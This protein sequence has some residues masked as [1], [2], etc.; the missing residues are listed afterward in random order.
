MNSLTHR[1]GF[2]LVKIRE[3][4]K[5]GLTV[6]LVSFPLS[7]SL[8]IASGATPVMG[9]ITAV[10][11]GLVAALLGGSHFNVVGPTGALS[12]LLL[13][14]ATTYGVMLMPFFT[15]IVGLFILAI[16]VLHLDKYIVFIP[17]SVLHG[18]TLGVAFIIGLNQLNFAFGLSG[19]PHHE[20]FL[21]NVWESIRH[22]G[23]IDPMTFAL[24]SSG[25]IL[26]LV[27][28]KRVPKIP[29]AIVLATGGI[30]LGYLSSRGI[31]GAELDTLA[32]RYDS[33]SGSLITLPTFSFSLL[34]SPA[35]LSAAAVA[36]VAVLET[37]ISAKIAD[38]ST[39]TNSDQR[40]EIFGLGAANIT[41]GLF[42]GIP[43]TAALARTSLNIKTGATH[44]TAAALN[45]VT[46]AVIALVFLSFFEY[47]PLAVVASILIYTAIRMIG[48][49][50]FEHLY[51]H[52]RA[53]FWTSLFVAVV[54][55]VEDPMMGIL[56]GA[57][58]ALLVSVKKISESQA[59][60]TVMRRDDVDS[61]HRTPNITEVD[62]HGDVLVYRIAGQLIY[63]NSQSHQKNIPLIGDSIHT[64]VFGLRNMF[65]IDVDGI[66]ALGAMID[67]VRKK[68]KHAVISGVSS[69]VEPML[70]Q[71]PW[72]KKL[73]KEGLVYSSTHDALAAIRTPE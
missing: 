29:W 41:S 35:L 70:M 11:A 24:A 26:L 2:V 5:A 42:G 34:H 50:H 38:A 19:L 33:L 37:L 72:F 56:V 9:I 25:L 22:V 10:W 23:Q 52:D 65:Y 62:Q 73:K 4:W 57:L 12:G 63:M 43:A 68:N 28:A 60:F 54:T 32:T 39:K 21:I 17:A 6:S 14:V 30:V 45:S 7:I 64:V 18:F 47:L 40:R 69:V 51:K 58:V 31:L 67:M 61:K 71:S 53:A 48:H 55:V 16:W 49:E 15:I 59:E 46:L 66:D 3:N 8:A 36:L 20:L 13:V 44:K 1:S 27:L